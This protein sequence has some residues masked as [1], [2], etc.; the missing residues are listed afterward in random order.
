MIITLHWSDYNHAISNNL[1]HRW[2]KTS[3]TQLKLIIKTTVVRFNYK[4][5]LNKFLLVPFIQRHLTVYQCIST[6]QYFILKNFILNFAE[7]FIINVSYKSNCLLAL[8]I[9]A[10]Y[11]LMRH[12][13]LSFEFVVQTY[14]CHIF[15]KVSSLNLSHLILMC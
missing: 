13:T 8:L 4:F 6:S 7:R 10:S 9:G 3:E 2:G 1:H 5:T 12:S 14:V 15:D 11:K